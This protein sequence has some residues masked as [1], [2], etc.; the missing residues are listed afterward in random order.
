MCYPTIYPT[1]VTIYKPEK[2]FNS[3]TVFPANGEGVMLINMNGREV[4]LWKG[5]EG[6]PA[7]ILPGGQ[8]L[9]E[10]KVR[11]PNFMTREYE[12][13]SQIDWDGHIV[14]QFNH[15]ELVED[16]GDEPRWMARFKHDIQREGSSV[17]YYSPDQM[18]KVEGGKSML[19][20][21]RNT[22]NHKI[23]RYPLIDDGVIEIDWEG[24]ILWSWCA[25]DHFD[26]FGFSEAAKNVLARDPNLRS[27]GI[28]GMGDW[29]HVNAMCVL[30][31]N[32]WYDAGDERFNPE[33]VLMDSREASIIWIVSKK[34]GEIVWKVGPDWENPKH[35][36]IG[37]I[38]GQH[39]AH[40]IPNGLPGAGNIMCFD[41]GGEAGYGMPSLVDPT[42]FECNHR[43]Y[44]RVVEFNPVTLEM[45]W[46][47]TPKEAG[48]LIPLNSSCFYSPFI[49]S[50]QRLPNGNTL[51]TEGGGGRLFEVTR[52][53]EIVWEYISPYFGHG[54]YKG[55]SHY[56]GYR[57]NYVYR[58][59][60]VPYEWCPQAGKP[61]ETPIAPVVVDDF[62]MPGAAPRGPVKVTM[63]D[64]VDY[65]V[66]SQDTDFCLP[67]DEEKAEILR[68]AQ[69]NDED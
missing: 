37:M 43:D 34:T 45:E 67:T 23:T 54:E 61:V 47:Y 12:D 6:F 52:D 57:Y 49:S 21:H 69:S 8:L 31:P 59:Y 17:G 19:L 50:A 22:K 24:N 11:N 56:N 51:I 1:G 14:W 63:V 3:F 68:K 53:Y 29:L 18:P 64:G 48:F 7:K 65:S 4:N 16:P 60:R 33:N 10:T 58:S 26:E 41:N 5:V 32:K 38:I 27:S 62:R 15:N 28:N 40:M 13:I 2:C 25:A 35:K 44:S 39:H 46:K 66:Q 9:A 20:V 36:D 55:C 42:G 30:G